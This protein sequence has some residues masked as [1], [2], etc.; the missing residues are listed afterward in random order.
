MRLGRL[1]EDG[2][3]PEGILASDHHRTRRRDQEAEGARGLAVGIVRELKL[4]PS[5]EHK[6]PSMAA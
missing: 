5:L 2:S 3:A 6:A 4:P 1:G